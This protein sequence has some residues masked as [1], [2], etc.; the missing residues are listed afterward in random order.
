M[1]LHTWRSRRL[2]AARQPYWAFQ[3]TETAIYPALALA[4]AGYCFRRLNHRRS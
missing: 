4:L 3:L 1:T 2:A